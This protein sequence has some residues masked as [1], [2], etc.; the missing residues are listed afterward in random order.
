[1]DSRE[2]QPH[3]RVPGGWRLAVVLALGFAPAMLLMLS[4]MLSPIELRNQD[5]DKP[6]FPDFS[7]ELSI[8][9]GGAILL[10][11]WSFYALV[12][13]GAR[14]LSLVFGTILFY[15]VMLVANLVVAYAGCGVIELVSRGLS[16]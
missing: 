13:I 5:T 15:P 3:A 6:S 12:S 4:P 16:R 1:M 7:P 11:P 9:L 8:M 14:G 10:L 2:S